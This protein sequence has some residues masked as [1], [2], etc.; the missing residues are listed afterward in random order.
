MELADQIRTKEIANRVLNECCQSL[1]I[2][3][4]EFNSIFY[5]CALE[6]EPRFIRGIPCEAWLFANREKIQ[7]QVLDIASHRYFNEW[8]YNLPQVNKVSVCGLTEEMVYDLT[9]FG[10]AIHHTKIDYIQ[11]LTA[12]QL[13][14]PFSSFD[15]IICANVL[16]HTTEPATVLKNLYQLLKPGGTLLLQVP[17]LAEEHGAIDLWRFTLGGLKYLAKLAGFAEE[18]T[19]V[20]HLLDLD[21]EYAQRFGAKPVSSIFKDGQYY[22]KQAV[23]V[24]LMVYLIG[25]K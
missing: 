15:T 23:G 16:E 9:R 10:G 2:N 22:Q 4:D 11:D 3:P 14:I 6:F 24:P 20:G 5:R 17:H 18:N 19:S 8:I 25:L 7:G 21:E 12:N 1:N 13:K